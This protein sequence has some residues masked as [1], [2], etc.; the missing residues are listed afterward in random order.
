MK[1]NLVSSVHVFLSVEATDF[2]DV[3]ERNSHG[4]LKLSGRH[5]DASDTFR[6]RML[7]LKTRVQLEEEEFVRGGIVEVLDGSGSVVSNGLSQTLGGRLHLL[8]GVRLGNGGRTFLEDLLET[9]LG[10]AITSVQSN[11]VSVLVTDD[12]N[13][14]VTSILTELHDE[15]GTIQRLRS[16]PE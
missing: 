7:D 4:D 13:F 1:V 5:V 11:G 8:E 15:N 14:Q 12:L 9:T 10:G 2:R 3:V 16:A 6:D